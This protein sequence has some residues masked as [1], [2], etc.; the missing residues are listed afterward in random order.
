MDGS[1]VVAGAVARIR[2]LEVLSGVEGDVEDQ[3]AE[4]VVV[5][6]AGRVEIS[7][8]GFVETGCSHYFVFVE[9]SVPGA[10]DKKLQ[11]SHI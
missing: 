9:V 11:I 8:L 5:A 4:G 10:I 3:V 6:G 7:V 2:A 1:Q